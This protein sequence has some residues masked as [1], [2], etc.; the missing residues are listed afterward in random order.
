MKL[1]HV[2]IRNFKGI[3][4]V[5][6]NLMSPVSGEPRPLTCLI[7]DNGSGKT[8]VLQAI[9]LTLS[10][11]TRRTPKPEEFRWHGF[12][13]ERVASLGPTLVELQILLEEREIELTQRLYREWYDSHPVEW[14]QSR[15]IIEPTEYPE[16]TLIY[17]RG[18]LLSP[19]GFGA[20]V[21]FL[22]RF[23]IKSL[24]KT[25]PDK[26]NLFSQLGDVFWFD[27]FRNLGSVSVG[28]YEH[29]ADGSEV[30]SWKTGV[31]QL[32]EF[33]I[34]MWGYHT[35]G[36]RANGTDYLVPLQQRFAEIFPGTQF[37][38]LAL[39]EG[40]AAPSGQDDFY[41][42]LQR[43]GKV[44][45]I[46][47]MSSGEQAVFPLIYEFIRLN[48]AHSLVLI[49][50][51]E[52]HLHPPEQQALLGALRRIGPDSQFL[53]TTHSPYLAD[54]IPDEHEVRLEGGRRCL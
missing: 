17:E 36:E 22:G 19:Q 49:D 7:G 26:R 18:R 51:F 54:A 40:V 4:E 53:V 6:M 1:K 41:F 8:T 39:R 23:Y 35:S 16:V 45:D 44:Y 11:A 38:G 21:Q 52:L 42:L 31:E 15:R 3:K 29:G 20:L 50:E 27:Q 10:L 13:P 30:E 43:E 9:A 47:E 34:G 12:L 24:L 14:L 37:Q 33:L 28:R 5:S 25:Q 2:H 48:I 32:R 46:A